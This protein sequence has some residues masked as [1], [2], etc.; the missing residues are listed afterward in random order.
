M[1]LS[2][3]P[4]ESMVYMMGVLKMPLML[5]REKGRKEKGIRS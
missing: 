4:E 2:E 5:D 3:T 1:N